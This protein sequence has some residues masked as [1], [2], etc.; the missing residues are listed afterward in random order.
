[1]HPLKWWA[2]PSFDKLKQTDPNFQ[3]EIKCRQTKIKID[4]PFAYVWC[5]CSKLCNILDGAFLFDVSIHLCVHVVTNGISQQQKLAERPRPLGLREIDKLSDAFEEYFKLFG[6]YAEFFKFGFYGPSRLFHS[7]WAESI[8]RWGEN[9]RSPRKTIA[10][11]T[12]LV[13]LVTQAGLEPTAVRWRV[14]WSDKDHRA[15]VAVLRLI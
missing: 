8:I 15:T 3:Y 11:R 7:F 10:S 9:G 6:A 12:W 4:H 2:N 5:S 1:M 14:I 13:P